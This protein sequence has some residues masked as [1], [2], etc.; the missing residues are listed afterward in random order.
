M[1]CSFTTSVLKKFQPVRLALN[2]YAAPLLD[3]AA[4]LY[5]A[6]AF[7]RSGLTRLHDWQTGN[8]STQIFLFESEHPVP[9]VPPEIAAYA[10]TVGELT[11]PVLVFFGLFGRVGALGLLV[12][13]LIIELTYIHS[14]EHILWMFLA[15][16]VFV[17]GPG[18]ISIDTLLLRCC[19]K[20]AA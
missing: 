15:A 12:M 2:E 10:S 3:L 1:N 17:R 18:K 14:H 20:D 8:F 13:A 4:R 11:L 6:D 7:F 9:G 16:S 5:L 19:R